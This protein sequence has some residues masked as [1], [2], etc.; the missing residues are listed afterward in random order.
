MELSQNTNLQIFYI[1]LDRSIERHIIMQKSLMRKT[2]YT[3]NRVQG[4]DMKT[5]ENKFAGTCQNMN[6]KIKQ[7]LTFY[8]R[9]KEIAIMLS[10]LKMLQNVIDSGC[11]YAL[12]LEDDVSFQY[13]QNFDD[14]LIKIINSAPTNW[15]IIKLHSLTPKSIIKNLELYN[16]NILFNKI[17]T[18]CIQSAACYLI[19]RD[20]VKLLLQR[21]YIDNTFIFP[22]EKEYCVAECI[23]FNIPN[24]YV[25]TLPIICI[26]SHNITC[27]GNYNVIELQSNRLIHEYWRSVFGENYVKSINYQNEKDLENEKQNIDEIKLKLLQNEGCKKNKKSVMSIRNLK[28]L[29]RNSNR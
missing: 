1:N 7:R 15:N 14:E 22:Y 21:Y 28:I 6:Y 18:E 26:L 10:H 9:E 12:C 4:I 3:F 29:A 13:M 20:A 19:K 2:K 24:V 23:L 16:K 17:D 5:I 11:D 8:P 25:Y 27:A